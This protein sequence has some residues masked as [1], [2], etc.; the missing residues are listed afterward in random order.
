MIIKQSGRALVFCSLERKERE[1]WRPALLGED[2]EVFKPAG[3]FGVAARER[4]SLL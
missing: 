1:C 4:L 2:V 3:D